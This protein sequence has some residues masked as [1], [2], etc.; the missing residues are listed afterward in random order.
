MFI[1]IE[2]VVLGNVPLLQQTCFM[3][4]V[5]RCL[6]VS[7]SLQRRLC[8]TDGNYVKVIIEK[9]QYNIVLSKK[10]LKDYISYNN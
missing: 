4:S 9:E 6:T 10:K 1:R 5:F 8:L 7:V 2:S 3:V